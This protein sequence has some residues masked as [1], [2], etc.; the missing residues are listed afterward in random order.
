MEM[1]CDRQEAKQLY[2]WD[3]QSSFDVKW[4][5]GPQAMHLV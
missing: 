5:E 3:T 1:I 4:P 2:M